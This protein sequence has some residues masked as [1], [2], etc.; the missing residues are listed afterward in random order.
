MLALAGYPLGHT[1]SF[2]DVSEGTPCRD[3]GSLTIGRFEDEGTLKKFAAQCDVITYE[4]ENVPC[5]AAHQLAEI[6]PVYP[7][8]RALEVSQ[9]RLTEKEFL[10]GLDIGTPRFRPAN[11]EQ[12]LR[13]ACSLLGL[14]C[15]VKTRRFGY[16]G[17]GQRMIEEL[18]S[19]AT[20]WRD[21]GGAP[22][23]VEGFVPFSRELSVVAVRSKD[24]EVLTYPLAQNDHRNG[25]LHRSEMPAPELT[26]ELRRSA[27]AIATKVLVALDYVGVVALELF[28]VRGELLANEIAPRVH[29]SG[30]STID[31]VITSQFENH[32]R[33]IT[34]MPL[35]S[36]EPHARA[37][38]FNLIGA[39]PPLDALSTIPNAKLHL[40]G[41]SPRPGR[42]LGH[43][44]LLNPSAQDEARIER[45]IESGSMS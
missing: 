34:G 25:I 8:P 1:F 39:I 9:D 4:F 16:D 43:I 14:P 10:Q 22:L 11:S 33:A 45:T 13:D 2:F 44:T 15:M 19:V 29:N 24:G 27:Q 23:I 17:K 28:H 26:P 40:Y 36:V 12:E 42:K 21:L 20:T 5:S 38:M 31:G 32:I 3:L 30:H 41:K 7:P 6:V 37:V 35:G 18:D